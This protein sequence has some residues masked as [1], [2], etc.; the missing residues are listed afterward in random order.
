MSCCLHWHFQYLGGN[1]KV[2][3]SYIQYTSSQ[4]SST[5]GKC[6]VTVIPQGCPHIYCTNITAPGDSLMRKS[7]RQLPHIMFVRPTAD[8]HLS[9]HLLPQQCC[10]RNQW[11][12]VAHR[13][14]NRHLEL[15]L[16]DRGK[17]SGIG[18]SPLRPTPARH[19]HLASGHSQ[20]YTLTLTT[21]GNFAKGP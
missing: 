21:K 20:E 2:Q 5:D 7:S 3:Q 15:L 12:C 17:S 11:G 1:V 8:P 9:A 4:L 13:G 16:C 14:S 19:E 6:M 10:Q 18:R